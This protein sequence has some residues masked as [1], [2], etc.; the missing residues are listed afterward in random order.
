M[1]PRHHDFS[2]EFCLPFPMYVEQDRAN[3]SPEWGQS[4]LC[5]PLIISLSS[6][7]NQLGF[8]PSCCILL[9]S[10]CWMWLRLVSLPWRI[11]NSSWKTVGWKAFEGLTHKEEA[12]PIDGS[13]HTLGFQ[14]NKHNIPHLTQATL[15]RHQCLQ[16]ELGKSHSLGA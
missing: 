4:F 12:K 15:S 16:Q 9:P 5:F 2:L 14:I 13:G 1:L 6:E 8:S 10:G 7:G 3:C 11:N